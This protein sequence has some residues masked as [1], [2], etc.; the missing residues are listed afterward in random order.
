MICGRVFALY[1][2][3]ERTSYMWFL[4]T[5]DQRRIGIYV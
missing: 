1:S 3:A 4:V 2:Y 5:V